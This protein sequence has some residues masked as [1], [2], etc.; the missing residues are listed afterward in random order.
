MASFYYVPV[1]G[2]GGNAIKFVIIQRSYLHRDIMKVMLACLTALFRILE[3][4]NLNLGWK[5]GCSDSGICAFLSIPIW[6]STL[7]HA[8]FLSHHVM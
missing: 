7:G 2:S 8:I 4:P 1:Q 6:D 3:T 5:T